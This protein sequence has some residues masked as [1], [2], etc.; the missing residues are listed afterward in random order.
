MR[1]EG[2]PDAAGDAEHGP[3]GTEEAPAGVSSTATASPWRRG[4]RRNLLLAIGGCLVALCAA[5]VWLALDPGLLRSAAE[6]V[7][8]AATG[9]PVSI[10]ALDLRRV[11]GRTVI[12][13]RRVRI[14]QTTTER[15]SISLTGLRSQANG[16]GVRFPNGSSLEQFR[17]SID[18]SLAGRPRI[19]TVDATGAVLVATRRPVNDPDGPPP[20]ARL[21]VVPRLLLGLG[22]ERIVVHSGALE[23]RGRTLTQSA[24]LTAV[25]ERTD[26]GLAFRGELLVGPEVPA[27][28][29]DGTVQNPM[30][31]EWR[32]YTR[33]HG[34]QVP[35]E[36]V[37][38]LAGVLEP[39]PTVRATLRRISSEA[40]FLLSGRVARGRIETAT[41]DFTFDAPGKADDPGISLEDVRFVAQAIPDPAGWTV[42]GE[43]DWSRLPGGRTQ[44]GARSSSAG[45]PGSRDR[46]DGPPAASRF[47][48]SPRSPATPSRRTTRFARRSNLFG[49]RG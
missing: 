16:D 34:D 38:F 7:A 5:V 13:A 45:R 11:E 40:Q 20:L 46:C 35:M 12:E 23:Y 19:T 33:L 22:L 42:N 8:S 26:E 1:G 41:L 4:W 15:V 30:S 43:V 10:E 28:P 32:I 31:D 39:G 29:F 47:R 25:L 48:S 6:H 9:R 27:L 24:G 37:R 2:P 17:A 49:R 36:G 21:L 18:F 3:A 14:G 44:S